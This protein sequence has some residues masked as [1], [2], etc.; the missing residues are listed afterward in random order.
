[1]TTTI[2]IKPSHPSQG[3]F[4]LIERKDFDPAVHEPLEGEDLPASINSLKVS[5]DSKQ[6]EALRAEFETKVEAARAELDAREAQL[7]SDEQ[8]VKEQAAAN[9]AEA[10]RL[11]ALAATPP[12]APSVTEQGTDPAT[13]TKEQLH[14]SLD[15][16][17]IKYTAAQNKAELAALLG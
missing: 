17:G 16:K 9:D 13:M 14:A 12:V 1:M 2:K 11:A 6:I 8:A 3:E 7:R 10:R 15:A 4:V 5:I